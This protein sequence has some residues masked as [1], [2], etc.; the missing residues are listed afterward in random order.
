MMA[1]HL[2]WLQASGCGGCTMSLLGADLAGLFETLSEA[3]IEVGYH[4]AVGEASGVCARTLIESFAD[5]RLPVGILCVEGALVTGPAGS[6]RYHLLA[7]TD[8]PMVDWVRDIAQRARHVV[9]IGSCTAFGGVIAG[10]ENAVEARGLQYDGE[11]P[12][13]LLGA[14]FRSGSGSPVINV[15]G[16]PAHADWIVETLLQLVDGGFAADE[17]DAFARPR[18]FSDSLVHHGCPRNE[19]YE[20]KASAGRPS[21]QGCLME[22]LGCLGTQAHA[23]CNVRPWYG[24]GSCL[25]GG[26]PC[27]ACTEPEA[28]DPG[29]PFLETPKVAGI[30]TGLPADMPKAWF[31]ALAALSKSATPR[32]VRENAQADRTVVPPTVRRKGKQG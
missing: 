21:D 31:V 17:L 3:G 26:F 28:M 29:H 15:A 27:I 19:Y 32:R 12:G 6:G 14:A 18:T 4:P 25:R 8:R 9:A 22:N 16:C 13:G 30:P 20:F 1:T 24:E 2:V 11:T 7:G 5:G 23:D 10:G